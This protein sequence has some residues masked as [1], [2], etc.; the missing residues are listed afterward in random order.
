MFMALELAAFREPAVYGPPHHLKKLKTALSAVEGLGSVYERAFPS[1]RGYF[2][3]K[4][5]KVC[6]L[7]EE[8]RDSDERTETNK[9]EYHR[10]AHDVESMWW[11][12]LFFASRALPAGES[13]FELF[14]GLFH[15]F[16]GTML[17]HKIDGTDN[18]RS[19]LMLDED[20]QGIVHSAAVPFADVLVAIRRYLS[21]PWHKYQHIVDYNHAH[22]ALQSLLLP[23]INSMEQ[24]DMEGQ[25][26]PLNTRQPRIYKDH[27]AALTE[28]D[29]VAPP[30][31]PMSK[32]ITV[33]V[34]AAA[35]VLPPAPKRKADEAAGGDTKRVKGEEGQKVPTTLRTKHHDCGLPKL[36]CNQAS[37]GARVQKHWDD[38]LWFGRG[39]REKLK[40]PV[41]PAE[42]PDMCDEADED[43]GWDEEEGEG[44]GK[45]EGEGGGE[46]E[47]EDEG[48]D[49]GED[50]DDEE[51][52]CEVE[53][54]F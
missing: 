7:E 52:E 25:R 34:S 54:A 13:A 10:P 30:R 51:E 36:K 31:D 33:A 53:G 6:E 47:G 24:P 16:V 39:Q 41:V 37:A 20:L 18:R 19:W 48:G 43:E 1:G 26:V 14:K 42:D 9:A 28:R 5:Q 4:F 2:M 50:V 40:N 15:H 38:R 11:A 29:S 17:Q 35:L 32:S 12:L 21:I 8:R 3:A 46:G 22:I 44:G 45:G 27:Y 23:M 49:Q